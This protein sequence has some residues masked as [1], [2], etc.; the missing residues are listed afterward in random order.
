MRIREKP[1]NFALLLLAACVV[2]DLLF[3]T[4]TYNFV[5]STGV[6]GAFILRGW[7]DEAQ[8]IVVVV[9]G[10]ALSALTIA[11]N[12]AAITENSSGWWV[13]LYAVAFLYA[14]W[15]KINSFFRL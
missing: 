9:L 13:L 11:I 10:L 7:S 2:A 12:H 6:V 15:E 5:L 1:T 4:E 8:P 3:V 14:L